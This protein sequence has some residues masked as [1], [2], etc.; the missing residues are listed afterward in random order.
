MEFVEATGAEYDQ[1][2]KKCGMAC[3][4][5]TGRSVNFL[6]CLTTLMSLRNKRS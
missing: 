2:V 4:N 3:G 1:D 5:L 6:L